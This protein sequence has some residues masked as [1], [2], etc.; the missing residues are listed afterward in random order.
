MDFHNA[1][2]ILYVQLP[3]GLDNIQANLAAL[4]WVLYHTFHFATVRSLNRS[5]HFF[6]SLK[7]D[8]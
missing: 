1:N 4:I 3:F 7:T 6:K 5:F 2:Q 8:W